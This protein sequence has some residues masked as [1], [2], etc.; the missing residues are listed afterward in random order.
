MSRTLPDSIRVYWGFGRRGRRPHVLH[1]FRAR[2]L[3]WRKIS[4]AYF[5]VYVFGFALVTAQSSE[6]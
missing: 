4:S 2:Q 6:E 5:V 3:R 1:P